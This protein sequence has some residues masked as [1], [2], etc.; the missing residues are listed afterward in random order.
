M[1]ALNVEL[2]NEARKK[3]V[4]SQVKGF[5]WT[6]ETF[7]TG[8]GGHDPANPSLALTPQ[9]EVLSLPLLTF[10]PKNVA[11]VEDYDVYTIRVQCALTGSEA[12]GVLSNIGLYARITHTLNPS[13]PLLNTTF[14]YAIGTMPMQTKLDGEVKTFDLF[15][16]F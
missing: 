8:E 1:V 5:G 16:N 6:I 13:D 3:L 15:I 2:T 4:Q 7:A 12:V 9:V 14:L 11:L 10:G